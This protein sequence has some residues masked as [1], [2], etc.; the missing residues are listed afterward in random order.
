MCWDPSDVPDP[1]APSTFARSKLNW[2]EPLAGD[3]ARL[4]SLYRS[5]A[6]LRRERPDLTDPRFASTTCAYDE[7]ARWFVIRRGAT[8]I[9]VNFSTALLTLPYVGD[10]LLATD[11]AVTI[12]ADA[13]S[14]PGHTAA[15]LAR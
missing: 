12:T 11:D 6:R 4:L 2:A 3:H 5:L 1:Q 15:I 7:E 8:V 13:L 10:L 9:A 14:L